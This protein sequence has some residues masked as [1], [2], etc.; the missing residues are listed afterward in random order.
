M[1]CVEFED[2]SKNS[3]LLKG[4]FPIANIQTINQLPLE[5]HTVTVWDKDYLTPRDVGF[6]SDVSSV[7]KYSGNTV[8][9]KKLSDY[10]VLTEILGKVNK[11]TKSDFNAILVNRYANGDDYIGAHSDD[12]KSLGPNGVVTISI[13]QE[14]ILRIRDKKTKQIISDIVVQDGATR[15]KPSFSP[16]T[17]EKLEFNG[18]LYWMCGEFQ[19]HFTHEIPK[20][21]TLTVCEL[22]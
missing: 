17:Q 5:K 19:K 10:P 15:L 3:K 16:K 7:Y 14:R 1:I 2:N 21:K 22:V 20:Q 18:D 9:A 4:K 13:G 12:E 6:F 8:P 11:L